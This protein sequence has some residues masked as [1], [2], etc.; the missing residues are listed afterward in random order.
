MGDH[1][2]DAV[3]AIGP[4]ADLHPQPGMQRL[5]LQINRQRAVGIQPDVIVSQGLAETR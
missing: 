3:K 4:D 2:H 1:A 5:L